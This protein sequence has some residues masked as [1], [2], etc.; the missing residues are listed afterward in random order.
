M[1]A[2]NCVSANIIRGRVPALPLQTRNRTGHPLL[3]MTELREVM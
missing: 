2:L 3:K 1:P